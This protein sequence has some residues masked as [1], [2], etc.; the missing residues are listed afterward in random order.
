MV[1]W[2]EFLDLDRAIN[3]R[4]RY[5]DIKDG[6]IIPGIGGLRIQ[7]ATVSTLDRFLK[8]M[9]TKHGDATAKLCKTVLSGM[10]GLA[11]RRGALTGN[12]LRD[13]ATIPTNDG[14]VRALTLPEV[15]ALRAGLKQW[16]AAKTQAGR[17]PTVDMLDVVDVML[18]TGCRIGEAMA[19]RWPDIDLKTDKPTL[20]INGTIVYEEGK[21]LIIQVPQEHQFTATVLPPTFRRGDASTPAGEPADGQPARRRVPCRRGHHSG[22]EQ[23]PQAVAHGAAQSGI[24]VGYTAHVPHDRGNA[25]G[26]LLGHGGS[27]GTVGPFQRNCDQQALRA[28]DT[29]GAG[30]DCGA[31]GIRHAP[32]TK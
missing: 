2:A 27:I 5:E 20:T 26:G 14:E 17:Y 22:P 11:A 32:L 10:L 6:Y 16:E 30:H 1:W 13:V 28:E 25:S 23:L 12:P 29:R 21:G 31:A 8:T 18:A 9:R 15:V 19:I 4:R 24:P 3:T 7:E